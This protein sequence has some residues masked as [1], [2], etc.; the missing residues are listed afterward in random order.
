MIA[1]ICSTGMTSFSLRRLSLLFL[2]VGNLTFG[3]GDPTMAALQRELVVT[4]AWLTPERYGLIFSLAR[5]T[6]GTNLLAF[7][8]G[9][10]WQLARLRGAVAAVLSSSIPCAAAVVWFTYVY[11]LWRSNP[12]A[13]SAIGGTLA[14]A[15]GMMAAASF[16]LLRPRCQPGSRFR[17]AVI[18]AAGFAL[19]FFVKLPPIQVLAIGAVLGLIWRAPVKT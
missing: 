11:T 10:G 4:R 7:C 17:A 18:F 8:A 16:Q 12:L 13:M 1:W 9:I 2:R 5:A 14:A 3:G 15:V 6:P 19:S